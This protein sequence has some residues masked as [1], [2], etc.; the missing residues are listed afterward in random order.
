MPGRKLIVACTAKEWRALQD[1]ARATVAPPDSYSWRFVWSAAILR[2]G[3]FGRARL[4]PT[5]QEPEPGKRGQAI[6]TVARGLAEDHTEETMIHEMAHCLDS[7]AHAAGRGDHDS[8]FWLCYGAVW[9]AMKGA[10]TG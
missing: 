3:D 5:S 10:G 1:K 9:R 7:W 8:H 6:V 4:S 2:E